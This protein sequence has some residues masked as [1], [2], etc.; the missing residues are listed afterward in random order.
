[1]KKTH[2]IASLVMFAV[3]LTS[4]L[5]LAVSA[6]ADLTIKAVM[7]PQA[8]LSFGTNTVTFNDADP[9]STKSISANEGAIDV[10]AKVRTGASSTAT[11]TVLAAGDLKS[12]G[13]TIAINNVTW[14]A[15]GTG[16]IA[17]TLNN[18]S[19]VT[20]GSWAG[21]GHRT[22]TLTFSLANSWSYATGSYSVTSTFTLTAP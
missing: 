10:T 19:P 12:G 11:L 20:V 7:N 17:G 2:L 18:S 4:N 16:F 3:L 15:G 13:D 5:A 21:S 9:D 8:K 1:M 22:G 6:T 14:T